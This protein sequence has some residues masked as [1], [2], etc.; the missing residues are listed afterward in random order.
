MLPL[1]FKDPYRLKEDIKYKI[2]LPER[3]LLFSNYAALCPVPQNARFRSFS[4]WGPTE[5]L[6]RVFSLWS[7]LAF[8]LLS[9]FLEEGFICCS[10]LY[11]CTWVSMNLLHKMYVDFIEWIDLGAGEKSRSGTRHLGG[12]L[13]IL[14]SGWESRSQEI[15]PPNQWEIIWTLGV[16]P[17]ASCQWQFVQPRLASMQSPSFSPFTTDVQTK[18]KHACLLKKPWSS[19]SS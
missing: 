7:I 19:H 13:T 14:S 16:V 8:N 4:L 6:W 3:K 2:F 17:L 11:L 9:S 1:S 5:A 18:M 10:H 12:A 15:Q